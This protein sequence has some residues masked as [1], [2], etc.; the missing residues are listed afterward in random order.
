MG[1][2][3][4][5]VA[6]PLILTNPSLSPSSSHVH[7]SGIKRLEPFSQA[8][9]IGIHWACLTRR[10][11]FVSLSLPFGLRAKDTCTT[12]RILF[13]SFFLFFIFALCSGSS[14]FP[15]DS[16][17]Q[18]LPIPFPSQSRP[19]VLSLIYS[20]PLEFAPSPLLLPLF[21]FLALHIHFL[22]GINTKN[23]NSMTKDLFSIQ[24]DPVVGTRPDT[25]TPIE[26]TAATPAPSL[27]DNHIDINKLSAPISSQQ[28]SVPRPSS[29][30]A[31]QPSATTLHTHPPSVC[32]FSS[33]SFSS[34]SPSSS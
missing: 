22:T 32:L 18:T 8:K 20:T 5:T 14:F 9:N 19:F 31:Q 10:T 13:F 12:V 1:H 28:P 16:F 23:N 33:L 2:Y 6:H 4:R 29:S 21:F 34:S 25:N 15:F 30:K 24:E 17:V 7:G 26:A 11:L 27:L 3:C